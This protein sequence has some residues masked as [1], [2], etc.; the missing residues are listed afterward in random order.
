MTR[1]VRAIPRQVP[2]GMNKTE[3]AYADLL[4][5]KR[6]AGLIREY[7]FQGLTLKLADDTRYTPDFFVVAADGCAECHEVKG[8]WRDDAKVKIK[9]AARLYPFRFVAVR[10]IKKT[11][12]Y[13]TY[14]EGEAT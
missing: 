14:T 4:E 2:A 5:S 8:F 10:W 11:W 6:R 1:I 12:E 3:A 13:D 9:V 7:H